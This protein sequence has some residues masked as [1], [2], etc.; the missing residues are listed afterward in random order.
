MSTHRVVMNRMPWWVHWNAAATQSHPRPRLVC[1]TTTSGMFLLPLGWTGGY[2]QTTT[3]C[4]KLIWSKGEFK[5]FILN[6]VGGWR[7]RWWQESNMY[8]LVTRSSLGMVATKYSAFQ[9]ATH[10]VQ[11]RRVAFSSPLN[12]LRQMTQFKDDI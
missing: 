2:S 9:D 7:R 11:S 1:I 4:D 3:T 12:A 10:S 6:V 5:T 8:I